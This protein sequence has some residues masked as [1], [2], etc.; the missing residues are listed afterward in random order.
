MFSNLVPG[1]HYSVVTAEAARDGVQ[2]RCLGL[3][4]R[5]SLAIFMP[6]RTLHALLL[7]VPLSE[8][9]VAAQVL[10][11]G[12]GALNIDG[13]RIGYQGAADKASAT[14]QGMATSGGAGRIGAV[15]ALG[16]TDRKKFER[17]ELKGRWPTNVILVHGPG[18]VCKGSKRVAPGNGSGRTGAGAHGW[19][20]AYVGG[21][22]KGEG[23]V[24]DHVDDDGKET[25]ADWEC[26][27][28]CPVR[29]LDAQSGNCPTGP[30][31]LTKQNDNSATYDSPAS[32]SDRY[33]VGYSDSGGA[34]RFFPQFATLTK[35]VVWLDCLI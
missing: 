17:P 10:A 21:E 1:A 13:C 2:A 14:P 35:A 28:D 3:E 8:K 20:T 22:K 7:R 34:S 26:Q 16:R 19:Q 30:G 11:T 12:T 33:T 6:G 32:S 23:F 25:V 31:G 4:V 29:L 24:G 15:P 5:D 9:T 27:P 18:C